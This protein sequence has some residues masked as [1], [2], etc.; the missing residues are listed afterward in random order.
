MI[1]GD[2]PFLPPAASHNDSDLDPPSSSATSDEEGKGVQDAISASVL[3]SQ[4]ERPLPELGGDYDF[5]EQGQP[6]WLSQGSDSSN[7]SDNDA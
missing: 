4:E 7:G 6:H 3:G 1:T 5:Q 2:L